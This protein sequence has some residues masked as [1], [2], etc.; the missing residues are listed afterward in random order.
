MQ[1]FLQMLPMYNLHSQK[2]SALIQSVNYGSMLAIEFLLHRGWTGSGMRNTRYE[3][4]NL[5]WKENS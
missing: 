2:F 3:Y 1:T 5:N 4:H